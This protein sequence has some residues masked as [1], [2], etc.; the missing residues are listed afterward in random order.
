MLGAEPFHGRLSYATIESPQRAGAIV[1]SRMQNA[2][3]VAR[4][5][6]ADFRLLFE[7]KHAPAGKSL[8]KVDSGRQADDTAAEDGAVV[9]SRVDCG[10]RIADCGIQGVRGA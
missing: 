8:D 2:R 5:M 9:V 6:L 1:N 7:H 3:V 10:L 4:L